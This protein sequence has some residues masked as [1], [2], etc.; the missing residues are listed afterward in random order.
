MKDHEIVGLYWERNEDAIQQT[1][2]KYEAYLSKVAYNM[3]QSLPVSREIVK[4]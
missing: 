1:Q 3:K 2:M 4:H